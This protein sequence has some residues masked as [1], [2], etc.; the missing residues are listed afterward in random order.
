MSIGSGMA[1]ASHDGR[2]LAFP[3][4]AFDNNLWLL[5]RQSYRWFG[6]FPAKLKLE[7]G[8]SL[9]LEVCKRRQYMVITASVE[10]FCRFKVLDC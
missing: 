2:Y 8:P 1:F 9:A 7:I 10:L 3:G 5:K 6:S 4:Y